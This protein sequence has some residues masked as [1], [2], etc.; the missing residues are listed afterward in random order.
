MSS[1]RRIL[2]FAAL[3]LP[4][5]SA[6]HALAQQPG[7]APPPQP[8]PPPQ[9]Q[10]PPAYP[11][12]QPPAAYPQQPPPAYPQQPAPQPTYPQQPPPAYPQQPPAYAQPAP[13]YQ[14]PPPG[15]Q[16]P[17]PG[18]VAPPPPQLMAPPVPSTHRSDGEMM[19]LY[20]TSI[21]WGLGTGIWIDGLGNVSDPAVASIT[22]LLLGAAAPISMYLFDNYYELERG[23][24]SSI[25][26]GLTLGAVEGIAIAGTQWQTTGNGGPN[27][28]SFQAQSTVTFA[29]STVGGIGGYLYGEWFK[30]D[31]KGLSFIVSGAGWG[32][33]SG[34]LI[35]AGA[36][37]PT[38]AGGADQYNDNNITAAQSF[39]DG[40]SVGGLIGYNAGILAAGALNIA[41]YTPSWRTQRAMWLGWLLGTAAGSLVYLGY[42]GQPDCHHGLIANGIGGLAGVGIAAALTANEQDT[43]STW[44]PPIQVGV[45]PTG[46]GGAALSAYGT[47]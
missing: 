19:A 32:A 2:T 27:T 17:P 21:A 20:V 39:G 34:L 22:P 6:S 16:A 46:T 36:Q 14:P 15:Y 31:P 11:Q 7:Y 26:T 10:P 25:A 45:T 13:V 42:I 30:P 12:Q 29:M 23:V 44:V 28:W 38:W 33:M 24:P 9:Q 35:G 41:G 37:S 3:A 4:L 47:W 1:G 43:A 40:A 18:Y 8:L 5:V